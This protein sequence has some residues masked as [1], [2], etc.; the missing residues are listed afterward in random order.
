MLLH[1]FFIENDVVEEV[2]DFTDP[3]GIEIYEVVRVMEGVPLFLEDHLKRFYHSAWL[4]HLGI[5]LGAEKIC[6]LLKKLIE[7]N[8]VKEGNIRFSWS[9]R[10]AGKFRAYFISHYYP[11]VE[12]YRRGVV[13]GLLQ[14][15]RHDPNA[16]VVQSNL[17]DVANRLMEEKGYY[18]VILV[19]G[20]GDITE[21]SRSNLFF[22]KNGY[23]VTA[24][25]SEVLPGITRKKMIDLLGTLGYPFMEQHISLADLSCMEA[26]FITG[27]SPKILPIR[28]VGELTIPVDHPS[29]RN[30]QNEYDRLIYNYI[31]KTL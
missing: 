14:A 21:G 5:P 20:N 13:C 7:V 8:Q 23:F 1:R 16:K 19:N 2:K 3:E 30:L 24:P 15:E 27:T 31:Q 18:E 12:D 25:A 29:I 9:W 6:Y 10:P 26:A 11:A 4:L 22:V 17:R 28:Q